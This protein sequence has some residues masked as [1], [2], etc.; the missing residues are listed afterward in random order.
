MKCKKAVDVGNTVHLFAMGVVFNVRGLDGVI[1]G[2][3]L[4]VGFSMLV[5]LEIV[6][7]C[8]GYTVG[9]F[10]LPNNLKD[11]RKRAS[12]YCLLVYAFVVA[13]VLSAFQSDS[14]GEAFSA[15]MILGIMVFTTVH[16]V[17][18]YTNPCC[19]RSYV[20]L[21]LPFAGIVWGISMLAQTSVAN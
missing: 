11:E 16:S 5:F 4:A 20:F 10:F 14:Y 6:R 19:R 15:G 8:V 13:A 3:K 2:R 21:D 9:G 1:Y 17:L 18:F 7:F 12:A